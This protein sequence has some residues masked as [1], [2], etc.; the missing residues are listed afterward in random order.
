VRQAAADAAE[1]FGAGAGASRLISG[2]MSLHRKLEDRLAEFKGSEAALLFGSG[3]LANTGTVAAL[4]GRDRVVF[5]DELNHASIIDGCRLSRAEKF[6]Y[7]HLDLEHLEWGLRAAGRRGQ[8]IVTDGVF[9][10]DGDVAPLAGLLELARRHGCMLMVDEAHGTGALGPGG[11]GSVAAAGLSGEVDVVVGTLGKALGGYG[12]YV[13]ASAQLIE[14]LIN[15]ARPFIYS[16]APPPPSVGAALAALSMLADRPGM[17]EQLRRN[18]ATLRERLI[19]QGLET[20]GSRTQIVPVL[21][22]DARRAMA[23]CERTL[24]GG[25]FAQAIRPP[26]VPA[27]SS[28]LRLTVMANHRAEELRHAAQVIGG[29]ARELGVAAAGDAQPG[30]AGAL[31]RAA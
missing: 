1:R 17:V 4:A 14:L 31:R 18:A 26:T 15:T 20:G 11:R 16:T 24:E 5:S 9:S 10:M 6:V 22:G 2:S 25:V 21:V 27:G 28:R 13:C 23:L 30:S 29:A 3:Y 8:L 12:A 7:R 19:G